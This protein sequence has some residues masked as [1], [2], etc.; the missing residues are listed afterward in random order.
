MMRNAIIE[1]HKVR[2][3][4][5]TTTAAL[6]PLRAS[7]FFINASVYR[8]IAQSPSIHRPAS[9]FS[10]SFQTSP[11]CHTKT[12][13]Q[14]SVI[15]GPTRLRI[16]STTTAPGLMKPAA[17]MASTRQDTVCLVKIQSWNNTDQAKDDQTNI[18]DK[19][20]GQDVRKSKGTTSSPSS[21]VIITDSGAYLRQNE[22]RTWI[23]RKHKPAQTP[24]SLLI[25][26]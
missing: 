4:F 19:I 15:A 10:R 2:Y 22:A 5:I 16:S 6:L 12:A 1:A 13:C 26:P 8:L 7:P 18:M 24:P 21:H 3:G 9:T 20:Q 14:T 11:K 23:C 25:S 17:S